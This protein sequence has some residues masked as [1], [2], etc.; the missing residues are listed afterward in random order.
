MNKKEELN[1]LFKRWQEEQK[2]DNTDTTQVKT[3]LK[4]V[5]KDSFSYDGFVYEEK[6]GT[7]LYILAESDLQESTKIDNNEFW[8]KN[9]YQSKENNTAIPRR[10][11]EMQNVLHNNINDIG[12]QD[13]SY[14]NINKRGGYCPCDWKVL[15][16]YYLKYRNFI[17]KEINIIKPK[18]IVFCAGKNSIDIYNEL[19]ENKEKISCNNILFMNHPSCRYNDIKYM[20]KFKEEVRK[21]IFKDD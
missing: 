19:V 18:I 9:I 16:R 8:F 4:R 12:L 7:V 11:K 20:E 13:I 2:Q 17:W 1:N 5:E 15:K 3:M 21:F 6:E 10:I 14:M